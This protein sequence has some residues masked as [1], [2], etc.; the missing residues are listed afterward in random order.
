MP[1][2][3]WNHFYRWFVFQT[4]LSQTS[5]DLSPEVAMTRLFALATLLFA[6]FTGANAA[7]DLGGCGTVI[8][9]LL[10]KGVLKNLPGRAR[11]LQVLDPSAPKN[12]LRP[13]RKE[14][15]TTPL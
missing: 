10:A 8:Q 7:D 12:R 1:L 14:P 9:A 6:L 5:L 13:R 15:A 4:E 11:S 2:T 3:F